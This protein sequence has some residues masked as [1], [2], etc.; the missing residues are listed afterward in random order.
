MKKKSL[1]SRK[2]ELGDL[3]DE[4]SKLRNGAYREPEVVK[5]KTVYQ[6]LLKVARDNAEKKCVPIEKKIEK[7]KEEYQQAFKK[8]HVETPEHI[9]KEWGSA[10][11]RLP[12]S[13]ASVRRARAT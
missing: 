12:S 7:L 8:N 10:P 3:R 2:K 4:A 6:E 13:A 5:A 9:Q 11:R 1:T